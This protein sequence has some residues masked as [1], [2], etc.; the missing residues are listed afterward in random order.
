MRTLTPEQQRTL[1]QIINEEFGSQLEFYDF[2]DAL[3]G[4]F[5]DVPGFETI[6]QA[7]GKRL[8]NQLWRKYRVQDGQEV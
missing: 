3:L 6:S 4:L 5:E 1:L 7:R 8:V 2:A